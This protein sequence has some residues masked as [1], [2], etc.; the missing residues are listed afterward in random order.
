MP[1]TYVRV[2]CER[3]DMNRSY[4]TLAIIGMMS[5]HDVTMIIVI[6]QYHVLMQTFCHIFGGLVTRLRV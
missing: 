3:G 5:W 2:V 6:R 1:S 4:V